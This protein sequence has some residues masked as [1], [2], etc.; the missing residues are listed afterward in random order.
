MAYNKKVNKEFT[1]LTS[2]ITRG[3][4]SLQQQLP[5]VLF[6][7]RRLSLIKKDLHHHRKINFV[8]GDFSFLIK[9]SSS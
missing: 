2:F 1:T 9:I 4:G 5:K 7:R 3:Y 8:N 6:A